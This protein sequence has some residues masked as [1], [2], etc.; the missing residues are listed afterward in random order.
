M[1]ERVAAES[2]LYLRELGKLLPL[3]SR[4]FALVVSGP[5]GV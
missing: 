1:S 2:G 4:A 5:S 3:D